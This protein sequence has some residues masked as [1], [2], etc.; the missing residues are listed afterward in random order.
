MIGLRRRQTEQSAADKTEALVRD[1]AMCTEHYYNAFLIGDECFMR[2]GFVR[3]A[4]ADE[5]SMWLFEEDNYPEAGIS[6]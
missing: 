4:G 3:T 1:R 2:S 5:G 6:T